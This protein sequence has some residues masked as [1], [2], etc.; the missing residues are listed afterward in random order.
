VETVTTEN[1]RTLLLFNWATIPADTAVSATLVTQIS[2]DIADGTVIDNL[3]A[4]RGR[5]IAY[6]TDVLTIGMPPV[7]QPDFQ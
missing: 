2:P 7:L 5:N 6:S 1:G 4:M 3:V